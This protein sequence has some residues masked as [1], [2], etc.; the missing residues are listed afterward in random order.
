MQNVLMIQITEN[1]LFLVVK[2]KKNCAKENFLPKNNYQYVVAVLK[3]GYYPP[4]DS[5]TVSQIELELA[6]TS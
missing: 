3:T 1:T 6:P 5:V 2:M 4:L